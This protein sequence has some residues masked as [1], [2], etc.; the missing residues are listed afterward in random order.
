MKLARGFV[1]EKICFGCSE[2]G[3]KTEHREVIR[4]YL[5]RVI[6]TGAFESKVVLLDAS[7]QTLAEFKDKAPS[8][9]KLAA[10]LKK[11]GPKKVSARKSS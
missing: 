5:D 9:K 8:P 2:F 6:K 10:A 11:A 3:R 7:G 1:C 4:D